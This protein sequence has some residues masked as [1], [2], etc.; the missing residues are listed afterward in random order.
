MKIS[1]ALAPLPKTSSQ[2]PEVLDPA[3]CHT[4]WNSGSRGRRGLGEVVQQ[5]PGHGL[6]EGFVGGRGAIARIAQD[7]DF[8]LHLHHD[9]AAGTVHL[10]GV[11]HQGGEGARVGL[12]IVRG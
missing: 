5:F 11:A 1:S 2:A 10:A 3:A 6:R 7:A 8:V 9:H 4:C 12:Q